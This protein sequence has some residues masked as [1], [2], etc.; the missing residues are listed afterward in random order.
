LF[1]ALQTFLS[2]SYLPLV[3]KTQN[4]LAQLPGEIER[5]SERD[6]VKEIARKGRDS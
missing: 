2:H 3:E 4:F 5:M 1:E 6:R